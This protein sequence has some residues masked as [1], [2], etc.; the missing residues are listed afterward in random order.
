[1]VLHIPLRRVLQESEADAVALDDRRLVRLLQIRPTAGMRDAMGIQNRQAAQDV[2][3][4]VGHVVGHSDRLDMARLQ[5]LDLFR[6]NML[7]A[8]LVRDVLVRPLGL[9]QQAFQIAIHQIGPLQRLAHV[10]EYG[11]RLGALLH[12]DIA[13]QQQ[14]HGAGAIRT[15]PPPRSIRCRP[16]R[17]CAAGGNQ[18]LR[19]TRYRSH[20]HIVHPAAAGRSFHP[21]GA[22]GNTNFFSAFYTSFTTCA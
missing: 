4:S 19:K 6:A 11:G 17:H 15:A 10:H 5:R 21:G 7:P 18:G 20:A 16:T 9:H 14:R 12:I 2:F 22:P 1:M 8:A 3:A 13:H